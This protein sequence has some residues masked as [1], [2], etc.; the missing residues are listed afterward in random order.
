MLDRKLRLGS[1]LVLASY[2]LMHLANHSLGLLSVQAMESGLQLVLRIW[3]NPLGTILLYGAF[4]LHYLLSLHALYRRSHL[5]MKPWE[6]AQLG[7]GLLIPPLLIGHIVATRVSREV[8]GIDISYEIVVTG[9]WQN[10]WLIL[11][12][13]LVML[14]VWGHLV[15]G[16]HFWLRLKSWY[17]R[18]LPILYPVAVL[19]PIL[20]LL[21]FVRAGFTVQ[22]LSATPGWQ[23]AVLAPIMDA[24][25]RQLAWIGDIKVIALSLIWGMLLLVLVARGI[26][27]LH[28]NRQGVYRLCYPSGQVLTATVGTTLLEAIRAAGIPH[29]SVCGGR[30][31]CTTCRVRIGAGLEHLDSPRETEMRA[32]QRIGAAPNVRLACQ[33]QPRFDLAIAPLL[34]ANARVGEAYRPGGVQGREIR[35]CF[36]FVDLRGSTALGECM[37]P[38]DVVFV[39]NQFFGELAIALK[40][41]DGYYAQFNGD[42][43]MAIYGLKSGIQQG[44]R[45]ALEGAVEMFS[46]LRSLNR[47]LQAELKQPLRMGIGIHSGEAIVGTMGPPASPIF[48]ALG[49][50][51]NIAARLEAQTKLLNCSLVVSAITAEHAGV[52]LTEFPCHQVETRGRHRPVTV[53]AII[54]PERFAR[55]LAD[56][57]SDP[58]LRLNA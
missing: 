48:S 39:L 7:L 1:G 51:V 58:M 30:G 6:A 24:D 32:L 46:R 37:L 2:V 28:Y 23:D 50:N 10:N 40:M 38:Y 43:L 42:G 13:T 5:R 31:R 33:I 52:D 29:A 17:P 15:V 3:S 47:S 44:C 14:I 49:D 27:R 18:Y 36:M 4:L 19:L 16:L 41:T 54:D 11:R 8:L 9:L 53:Y 22:Q 21:G 57:D 34:P 25:S 26:R 12:Q 20:S 55:V 56:K 45:Q 35:A